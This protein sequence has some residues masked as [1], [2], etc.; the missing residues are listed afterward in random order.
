MEYNLPNGYCIYSYSSVGSTNDEAIRLASAGYPNGTVVHAFEQTAGRGKSDRIWYSPEGNLY[1]S[2]IL[3]GK[4]VRDSDAV[5][6]LSLIGCLAVGESILSLSDTVGLKY[7]W[8]NDVMVNGRKISG[9]LP[10]RVCGEEG[11][12]VIGVGVNVKSP[13]EFAIGLDSV[14]G[15]N[16]LLQE[17][18]CLILNKLDALWNASESTVIRLWN[19]NCLGL[20]SEVE[21]SV[22]DGKCYRGLML[23]ISDSGGARLM[24]NGSEIIIDAGEFFTS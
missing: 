15:R 21:I 2:V 14:I 24:V 1:F 16:V 20:D 8:P 3:K 9:V 11:F 6:I 7:K 23:G 22:P 5:G 13:P 10:Y 4:R 17:F 12:A 18:L 19:E